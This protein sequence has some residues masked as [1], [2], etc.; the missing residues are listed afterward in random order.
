MAERSKIFEDHYQDYCRQIAAVDL[1]FIKDRLEIQVK[2]NIAQITF[3]N[4]IYQVSGHG[5]FDVNN[6][7]ADYVS[8]VIL[9]KY[10]LLCPDQLYLDADWCTFRDFKKESHFTNTNYLTSDTTQRIINHFSGRLADLK[11]ACGKINGADQQMGLAYDLSVSFTVLPR[12]SLLLL[13]NDADDD[14][15]VDCKVLFQKQGEYYL[16][17]ESLAMTSGLLAKKLI[18]ADENKGV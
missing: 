13:V 1:A 8:C 18:Q 9:S 16:D 12:L 7:K 5:I 2:N 17:P 4:Q 3:F 15:P 11:T 14:F 6:E 10:I